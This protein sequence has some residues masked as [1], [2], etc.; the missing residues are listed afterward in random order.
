MES[1]AMLVKRRKITKESIC[2]F[3]CEL[4]KF[5]LGAVFFS[6]C[7]FIYRKG[8]VLTIR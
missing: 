5:V 2:H 4:I 8:T 6:E 3:C 7:M 1:F